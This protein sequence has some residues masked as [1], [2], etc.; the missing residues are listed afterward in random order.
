MFIQSFRLE[1]DYNGLVALYQRS[2]SIVDISAHLLDI[3]K[4]LLLE[5]GLSF[6]HNQQELL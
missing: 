3:C 6:T 5:V 2:V 1:G 4:E